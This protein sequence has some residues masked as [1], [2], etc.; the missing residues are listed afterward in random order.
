MCGILAIHDPAGGVTEELLRRGL[1]A[2]RHRGPDGD[3]VW[4]SPDGTIGI[5]HV[6]LAVIDPL[7]GQQPIANEDGSIVAAV[8]GEFYGYEEIR[9][10]LEG[11]GHRF[12]TRSDSEIL[13]H[14]HED[15]PAGLFDYLN[16]EFAFVLWDARTR[17][18]IAGRDRFG[19]KP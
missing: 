14:L 13:V 5:G 4:V 10:D 7:T 9:R 12:R 6:R 1:D 16:G 11:N 19:A 3:G 2:V 17:R 18:L 15:D 8:N